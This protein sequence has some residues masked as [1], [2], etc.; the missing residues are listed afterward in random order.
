MPVKRHRGGGSTQEFLQS[1]LISFF[2]HN[3]LG[4]RRLPVFVVSAALV[5]SVVSIEPKS[6][7]SLSARNLDGHEVPLSEYNGR[8]S[9]VV[10][11]ACE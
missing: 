10:N 9:L 5:R 3:M 2:L 11:V 1:R 6:L 7:Y 8:V 4:L